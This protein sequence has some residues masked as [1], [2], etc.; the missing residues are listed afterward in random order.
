MTITSPVIRYHGGKF[1]L[2]P[3]VIEHFPPH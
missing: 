2:A 1:R 3:W